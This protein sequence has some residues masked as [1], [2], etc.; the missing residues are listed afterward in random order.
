MAL[1]EEQFHEIQEILSDRRFRAE[2]TALEKQKEVLTKVEGYAALEEE[3]RRTSADS[4]EERGAAS[5]R[6]VY[7]GR[8]GTAV[9]LYT[10]QRHGN[11]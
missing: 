5:E 10:L 3:L 1:T 2:K 9:W 11:L 4:G 6:R 8:A 7:F